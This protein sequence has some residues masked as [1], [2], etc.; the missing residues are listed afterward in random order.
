MFFPYPISAAVAL[1]PSLMTERNPKEKKGIFPTW[2]G[3]SHEATL[4]TGFTLPSPLDEGGWRGSY[5][6]IPKHAHTL[7]GETQIDD[8]L[9]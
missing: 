1:M 8:R 4:R 6:L 3:V 9:L 5:L 7:R 2:S